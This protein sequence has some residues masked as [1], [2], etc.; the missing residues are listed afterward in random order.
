M[1]WFFLAIGIYCLGALA[2]FAAGSSRLANP[3]GLTFALVGS[4]AGLF[5]AASP[6]APSVELF[7]APLHLPYGELAFRLDAL[8]RFFLLPTFTLTPLCAV[9]G[10]R[11]LSGYQGRRNL[12]S[13]WGFLLLMSA[14]MAL[15]PAANDGFLFLIVWEIMSL[16]P[17]FLVSFYD[18]KAEVREAAWIYLVAAHLGAAA[19]L[20]GMALLSGPAGS[21][22]FD[23]FR[24]AAPNLSSGLAGWVFVM[25]L[26]GFGAKAGLAPMHVWLPEAHP[27]APSHVSALMSGA[28][29]NAGVYGMARALD[30]LG[31]VHLWQGLLLLGMGLLTALYGIVAALVQKDL[32]RL[33]ALSTVENM[34]IA[35]L[36]LGTGLTALA[37]GRPDIAIL[38]FCGALLHVLNHTAFKGLL[39]LG[40]GAVLKQAHTVAL[41]SLGGLAKRM[42][43]T[44]VCFALGAA[45]ISGLPPFNGF[46]GE[47]AIYLSLAMG[48]GVQ[49]ATAQVALV[50]AFVGLAAVGGLALAAFARAHAMV[51]LGEPRS[52]VVTNALDPKAEMLIPMII[53][54]AL[55]LGGGLLA[56]ELL[57]MA[58]PAARIVLT[59]A[60]DANQNLAVIPET[61]MDAYAIMARIA[62]VMLALVAVVGILALLRRCLPGTRLRHDFRTW[63]CGY[64]APT[65]RME[66]TP[67]AFA[68]PL[69]RIFGPFTGLRQWRAP[70]NSFFPRK[71]GFVCE[72]NDLVRKY[73]LVPLFEAVR[74]GCDGLK[75][76]QSG[77]IHLYI[78]YMLITLVFLLVWKMGEA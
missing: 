24:A 47:F 51:F 41:D 45:A 70:L 66:Y 13:H 15:V 14:G 22:S 19:L 4:V 26:L 1:T 36:G 29:V 43:V 49:G 7:R 30:F 16:A 32:K 62:W 38:A 39:F 40:A 9:Y 28:L 2:C 71:A 11:Y 5:A 60:M 20:A 61:V 69:V 42:P 68:H 35:L 77:R 74:A 10:A 59:S 57:A 50:L 27:A 63:D 72:I 33:L 76:L 52:D 65:A 75:W 44:A 67:Y 53:L 18:E 37:T 46:V 34:G 55:C 54:A 12:G 73:V 25:L 6:W 48:L 64:A 8:C 3:L 31:P 58:M 56:P 78:L 21:F 17:F 23:A